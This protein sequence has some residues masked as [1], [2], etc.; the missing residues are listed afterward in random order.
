[1]ETFDPARRRLCPDG[2]CIGLIGD[3]HRC[4]ECGRLDSGAQ[5][6]AARSSPAV[7]EGGDDLEG[8]ALDNSEGCP[9]FDPSRRL[10]DDG[11]CVGVIGKNGTCAVCGRPAEV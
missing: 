10:C 2:A 4:K 8:D 9:G 7:A 6:G 5:G 1:M 3:D 11:A